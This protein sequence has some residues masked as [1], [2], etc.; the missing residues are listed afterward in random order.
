MSKLIKY[1]LILLNF[2]SI[3]MKIQ[4][5]MNELTYYIDSSDIGKTITAK[6]DGYWSD[7]SIC[8]HNGYNYFEYQVKDEIIIGAIS[9]I[10]YY[11]FHSSCNIE[12]IHSNG[13]VVEGEQLFRI[14]A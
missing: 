4:S 10:I 13:E 2:S 14:A 6:W 11:A 8:N 1:I 5:D 12:I 7:I 3:G 9:S